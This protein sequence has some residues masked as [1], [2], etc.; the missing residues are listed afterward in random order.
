MVIADLCKANRA[1]RRSHSAYPS[2]DEY[3]PVQPERLPM[4]LKAPHQ[5]GRT[6]HGK[7]SSTKAAVP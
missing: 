3:G 4:L 6:D 1:V 5:H 2:L 7:A